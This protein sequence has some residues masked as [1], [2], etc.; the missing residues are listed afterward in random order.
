[1]PFQKVIA[2]YS[3]GGA[4]FTARLAFAFA[5]T[6]VGLV[7]DYSVHRAALSRVLE[8]Q[9]KSTVAYG[10]FKGLQLKTE[11]SWSRNMLGPML[12]GL[13]EQ[14]VLDYLASCA[15]L[16]TY[17]ID[18]GAADGYYGVGAV[19]SGM[20]KRSICFEMSVKG[21]ELIAANA[22]LNGVSDRVVVLGEAT[23]SLAETLDVEIRD[24]SVVLLDIEGAEFDLVNDSFLRA[25]RNAIL[26]I[27][28]HD[29][30]YDD[31]ALRYQDLKRRC[32]KA[33]AVREV[34]SGARDLSAI[35][36]TAVLSDDER[37]ML[38][39]EGRPSL[40][41]WLLLEPKGRPPE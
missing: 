22:E 10:P 5:A 33:F 4:L 38:C 31:G 7:R 9:L 41:T 20:Y 24:Q 15:T 23:A 18:I 16:K 32:E 19:A 8:N 6:R 3:Y 26:I 25:F 30:F 34:R 21:R 40:G 29:G 36:E 28:I 39:S 11:S 1:M 35:A 17:L 37:W 14:E 13:Y 12:L 2:A 27:E